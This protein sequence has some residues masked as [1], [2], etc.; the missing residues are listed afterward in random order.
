MNK[1]ETL[2][3]D[4]E[5][6]REATPMR[7]LIEALRDAFVA[8]A[9]GNTEMS[10]KSYVN[11]P[12]NNGDFR[13][14]PAYIDADSWEGAGMKWV[15]VHPENTVQPTVMGTMI[16]SDPGTG[17]PL[18][19]LDG[20]ELTGRRTGAVAGLA[21]DLFAV[22]DATSLGIIGAG[23]QSYLQTEAIRTVRQIDKIV[24]VDRNDEKVE[25]F[26]D[27]FSDDATVVGGSPED[28]A[29]C[30]V[31]S[32]VTPSRSPIVKHHM[33]GENTHINAMGA[34]AEGKQELQPAILEN[35]RAI[36]DDWEQALHSGEVNVPYSNDTITNADIEGTLGEAVVGDVPRRQRTDG[37]TVF[38][39]TGLAIQD[40]AA[41]HLAYANQRDSEAIPT[42]D[43]V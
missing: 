40:V 11:I 15:S 9:T 22:E 19:L 10:A 3:L 39:S 1:S 26:I 41:A 16:Y 18:A 34:D 32:T 17:F 38:D 30:D 31:L 23:A 7:P 13:S 33:L 2:F 4:E 21:T 12:T 5:R 27:E 8:Y 43:L 42:I 28:A 14:M 37:V 24:I 25:A 20:T 29:N 36:I 35:G 6:V